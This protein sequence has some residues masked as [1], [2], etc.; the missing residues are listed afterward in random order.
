[1]TVG[2]PAF[3]KPTA[4]QSL[5]PGALRFVLLWCETLDVRAYRMPLGVWRFVGGPNAIDLATLEPCA[6]T[7]EQLGGPAKCKNP[8]TY[9]PWIEGATHAKPKPH[10][11]A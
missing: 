3:V 8:Y 6:V 9:E 10:R 4:W 1:M 7:V 5:A 11:L 2:R